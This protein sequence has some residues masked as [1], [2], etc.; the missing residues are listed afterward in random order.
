M[1]H[2]AKNRLSGEAT[3]R[4]YGIPGSEVFNF[5]VPEITIGSITKMVALRKAL[6]AGT[7]RPSDI[8]E[9]ETTVAA[10]QLAIDNAIDACAD[11]L[12]EARNEKLSIAG[13]WGP[14]F[15]I[16]EEIR[17]RGYSRNDFNTDNMIFT[18][19]GLKGAHL[20]KDYCEFI[21]DTFNISSNRVYSMYG[22]QE[23]GTGMP[24]CQKGGRYHLPPW[25]VCLPLD[26][27]GEELLPITKAEIEARAAFFDLSIDGRWGGLISGDR[28]QVD[29]GPC[30]CGAQ[31]PSIRDNIVRYSDIEGDDKIACSGTVDAYVRGVG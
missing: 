27:T 12:I 23:L 11:A 4:A 10:R 29:F 13:M 18:A 7:A 20:P 15:K 24:R 1:P 25:L 6:A 5:P 2:T 16:C 21:Y 22:M 30:E 26:K 19:G 28:I 31:S 9:F 14:I 3:L 8:T 17:R